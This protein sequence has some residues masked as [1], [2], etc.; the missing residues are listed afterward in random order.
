MIRLLSAL[1]GRRRRRLSSENL[2][3]GHP[4]AEELVEM[5]SSDLRETIADLRHDRDGAPRSED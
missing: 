1:L 5:D 4:S 3:L 2:R